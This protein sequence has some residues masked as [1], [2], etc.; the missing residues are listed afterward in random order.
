[1][2]VMESLKEKIK[3]TFNVKGNISYKK[4]S[5]S[6]MD[7]I[8]EVTSFLNNYDPKPQE[9]IYCILHDITSVP[10]C[11][12][13][14]KKLNYSPQF[15]KYSNSKE[16]GYSKRVIKNKFDFSK[17]NL[18]KFQKLLDIYNSD[19][20]HL[21]SVKEC[22]QQYEELVKSKNSRIDINTALKY[23]DLICNIVDYTDFMKFTCLN[24][25][26]RI[27]CIQKS[28]KELQVDEFGNPLKFINSFKGYSKY[29]SKEDM[30]RNIHDK[31]SCIIEDRFIINSLIREDDGNTTNRIDVTCKKCNHRY[32]PLF[33]NGLWKKLYCPGC[34]GFS[35][36][37]RMEEDLMEYIESLGVKN[38][39]RNDRSLLSGLEIDILCPEDNLAIE[40]C[41]IL[42]HSFGTTFPH[43]QEKEKS[44][45][46]AHFEKYNRCKNLNIKLLTI[47]DN[48]W[49]LK[50]EIVKSIISNKLGKTQ[51]RIFARKCQYS[52]VGNKEAKKF[53]DD[54]HI[55][56]SCKFSEAHGLYYKGELISLMCFGKRK[57]TRGENKNELI[58]F[59]NKIHHTI[60]GGASKIL[61]HSN[62][63]SFISYCDLRYGDG[64]LYDKLG[65]KL[66]RTS[67][68]NYWY[69]LDKVNLLHR[70]NFQKHK[71]ANSLDLNKTE[72][73]IMYDKGYR[74]IYD[75]GNLVFEY[76][77]NHSK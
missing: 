3:K 56:G 62:Q 6:L 24:I 12:H 37:S 35:G 30:N 70:S 71:I 7:E 45:K 15:K 51:N 2:I 1:M 75:C 48:E 22:L 9:R 55:Q 40:M 68:P 20:Y 66:I 57:I 43:N 21:L 32:T 5:P 39:K 4:I 25:S 23:V 76:G 34:N 27:Y 63:N 77:D 29:A 44:C 8:N 17:S 74:R 69:T 31:I 19:R 10:L 33:R 36:K 46:N 52:I 18:D 26:E 53:L 73:Q 65:M 72:W 14:Q 67:K 47:F 60:V 59:C 13:T 11:P 64:N 50:R 54:N 38:I 16:L 41:G 42:W 49:N 58:R 28:I 61:N